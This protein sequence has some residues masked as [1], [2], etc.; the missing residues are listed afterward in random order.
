MR[1]NDIKFTKGNGGMGRTAPSEDPVSALLFAGMGLTFGTAD[2]NLKGFDTL[3]EGED[4]ATAYIRKFEFAE[5]A[6]EAG[7]VHTDTDGTAALTAT[8]KAKNTLHY[9]LTEFFRLSPEGTLYLTIKAGDAGVTAS[10]IAETQNYSGG[11]IRQAGVFSPEL[12]SP[13]SV[14]S[15]CAELEAQHKPLSVV[16]TYSG[17]D[18]ETSELTASKLKSKGLCNVSVLIGCDFTEKL[19]AEMGEWAYYGCI[20]TA[21]GALSSA[22]VNESIAWVQKFPLGFSSPALFNGTLIRSVSEGNKAL[23]NDNYIFTL[24]HVGDADCYFNDSHTLDVV[25]SDYAYIENVR[26]IDK[27]CRGIRTSLLPYLNSPLKVDAETG[28]LNAETVANLETVAS[29]PLE[30]MEK[31]GELSGYACEIDPEQNVL[32]TSS[33]DIVIKQVGVGVM[34]HVSVKIGY[35]T[36]I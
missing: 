26:T 33:V 24:T 2:G 12:L 35:T 20:G 25:T 19:K 30:Q 9:H 23:L 14:Q 8:E 34:R 17:A 1:L 10:D 29:E 16:L 5:Q 36:S 15:Q 13:Q 11:R 18:V 32:A 31:A 22:S 3:T 27:A 21:I 4:G 7:I 28:K 6:E